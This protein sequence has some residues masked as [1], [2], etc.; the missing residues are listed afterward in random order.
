MDFHIN[1]GDANP[2]RLRDP[3]TPTH[4]EGPLSFK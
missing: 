3:R 2:P 1:Y 4:D